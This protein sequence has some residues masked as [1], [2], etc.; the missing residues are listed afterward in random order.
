MGKYA[1]KMGVNF[2][3]FAFL[4]PG[5]ASQKIGMC[6]DLYEKDGFA[7]SNIDKASDILDC[8][9]KSIMF[10]GP[11]EVLK[12]T[13]YTQPAMFIS[14][15]IIGSLLMSN[16]LK[17]TCAAGHSLGEF[18]AFALAGAFNFEEGLKLV[19]VRSEAMHDAGLKN[20][21]AMAAVIGLE[22][23]KIQEICS[24]FSDG[25]VCVANFN[26][27][28]QIVISGDIKAVSSASS[29][30]K[31]AGALKVVELNV[32]GAFHSPL[33]SKAKDAL[34]EHL[35]NMEINDTSFPVY[36]NFSSKPVS[37]K[38]EIQLALLNQIENPVLWHD[39]IKRMIE[40][41][42]STA[43]EIGPS[44]VLQGLSKRINRSLIMY[45]AESYEDI[46][47]LNNV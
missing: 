9:I 10:N 2:Q 23:N 13:I 21:G 47:N 17:P 41:G 33:M 6:K 46:L 19:K 3:N 26:S 12:Q 20:P 28:S 8:D 16:G 5:Q 7:R 36:T 11:D 18:S 42:I 4:C 45:G 44:K 40:D 30:I 1:Y 29:A 15:Y 14:S 38:A 31:D 25:I 43:V 34:H 39:I 22:G 35:S 37:L 32:S 27:P 24:S